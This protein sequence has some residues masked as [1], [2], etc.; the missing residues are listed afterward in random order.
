MAS[1]EYQKKQRQ[2]E[3]EAKEKLTDA[4]EDQLA[5]LQAQNRERER[6]LEYTSDLTAALSKQLKY[7]KQQTEAFRGVVNAFS[8]LNEKATDLFNVVTALKDPLTAGFKLIELSVKRFVELDNAAKAFRDTTGFLSSQTKEVET[9]IRQ[10]SRDLAEFGV[11]VDVARD[12]AA[13]LATAFGDTAIVNK[14]NLEY[15]SL[16]KQN[17][18]ISA[19]DSVSLM[20]NFMGIGGM[21]SQVARETAGAAASLAKAAGVPLGKVMQEVAKPSDTV[22]SLIRGSVDG[23]IKGAIEAKRLGTSLESV[24]KAAAGLLDFQSSINDEMEAS[25]LFGKDVNLQKARELSYAGD[26]KGLA[27]EQSRLLQEAGDVSK[28]D[29]FQRIGIAKAMGMTVEEMDKMNAKQQELNKLKIDDPATYA[30]YTAN[31]D[32]INKTNESLSEKYQK[33]LKSQQIAS[34]QEKIMNSINS[35]MTELADALLP[36]INTLVPILGFL[37]KISVVLIKFILAPFRLL[38]DAID[39]FFKTFSGTKQTFDEFGNAVNKLF[40]DLL[41]P[42]SLGGKITL[43]VLGLSGLIATAFM[44]GTIMGLITSAITWPFKKAFDVLPNYFKGAVNKLPQS[45]QQPIQNITNKL[46]AFAGSS[47]S[48]AAA[49]V[50][51]AASPV[52]ASPTAPAAPAAPAPA[53]AAPAVPSAAGAATSSIPPVPP[54]ANKTAGQNIKEFLTNLADGIKSFKPLGEILKGLFGIAASGPAFLL[55]ITAIPGILLMAAVGA[56]GPLIVGG[57][58]A[59]STGIKMMDIAKIGMGVLGILALG[60]AFIPFTFALSLLTGVSPTAILASVAAMYALGAGAIFLGSIFASG[61]G[62]ALFFAGVAGIAALG[63]AFIPFGKASQM[64]GEGMKNFGDGVKDIAANISQISSLEE[65]FSIF[66]DQE[67]IAGIYSMGFAIAFLNTQLSALGTNLP[68]LAEINKSKNEQS[69]NG[70]VVAKL[71]ELIGLMQSGAIAVNIDGSK[72]ST[73]VGVATRFKGAS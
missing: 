71:D 17:L 52:P 66:K 25:V 9:N 35:I 62:A 24:G 34:Q 43:F 7:T 36:V 19:D 28:M 70:E 32:T 53:A 26:L 8:P 6:A 18:G 31:L 64:A 50:P 3:L 46:T 14:E 1:S 27:K 51:A 37:L 20:Q 5:G 73:A 23:L 68:A 22:R 63:L 41:N 39:Y 61:I 54:T 13:A 38:N 16:M 69:A 21:T 60:A 57:F 47:V 44:G 15:V 30:R 48:D 29:Y 33:E 11:S 42:E 72:V 40:S 10:S 49:A 4:E 56:M 12:S 65:T 58:T 55:F 67:L 59:L 45:I 2:A